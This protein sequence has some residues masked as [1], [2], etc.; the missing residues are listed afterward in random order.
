M[1]LV[2]V[3]TLL[4]GQ[5][6]AI[7]SR[8]FSAKVQA[9]ALGATVRV[10]NGTQ[11][12]EGSGVV[13]G[14][15]GPYVYV[16]TAAHIA[17]KGDR[18]E[19]QTFS[20]KSYPKPAKVYAGVKVVAGAKTADLALLRLATRDAIPGLV[21][22]CPPK[23]VPRGKDFPALAAGC[24]RARA[25]RCRAETVQGKKRIRKEGQQGTATTWEVDRAI[26]PGRSGG[27]L[28]DKQG[29]LIGLASGAGDG[30]GYYCH[31]AE[32]HLFLRQNGLKWLYEEKKEKP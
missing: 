26:P 31:V 29:L 4:P 14:R 22:I 23:S 21:R 19:I 30:K 27:P 9:A 1:F 10:V 18:L 8:D 7:E 13:I 3:L 32:I 24:D 2:A 6:P 12:A 25:P 16:L 5:F 17:Q 15:S 11:K 20:A 28:L